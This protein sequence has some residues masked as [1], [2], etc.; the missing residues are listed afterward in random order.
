M[1]SINSEY[2]NLAI[3]AKTN[4]AVNHYVDVYIAVTL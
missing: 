2:A 4:T 1:F 3:G